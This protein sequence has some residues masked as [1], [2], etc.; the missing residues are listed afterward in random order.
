LPAHLFLKRCLRQNGAVLASGYSFRDSDCRDLFTEAW[1]RGRSR[2]LVILV[3]SPDEVL[4]RLGPGGN[5]TAVPGRFDPADFPAVEAAL[6][7]AIS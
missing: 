3:P 5:I 4:A 1:N 7:A 6:E 2:H